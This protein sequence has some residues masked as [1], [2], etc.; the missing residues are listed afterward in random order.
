MKNFKNVSYIFSTISQ[1]SPSSVCNDFSFNTTLRGPI[2]FNDILESPESQKLIKHTQSVYYRG[3]LVYERQFLINRFFEQEHSLSSCQTRAQSHMSGPSLV[4]ISMV[5]KSTSNPIHLPVSKL[6]PIVNI[7]TV[8]TG[9]ARGKG[10]IT[11]KSRT[12]LYALDIAG[13]L[14]RLTVQKI[15]KK[16]YLSPTES[17]PR[18]P[19]LAHIDVGQHL[20]VGQH[21][22][23]ACTRN[24]AALVAHSRPLTF[25][26]QRAT[27]DRDPHFI[28][29]VAT[30]PP[31]FLACSGEVYTA[32][33][34]VLTLLPSL[35]GCKVLQIKGGADGAV[36]L[37]RDRVLTADSDLEF[38]CS[39]SK[40]TISAL[41]GCGP[42]WG[43]AIGKS[44]GISS[45]R[46]GVMDSPGALSE[47]PL[48]D[49]G[50]ASRGAASPA[51]V[52]VI[53]TDGS[54][55]VKR[56]G[57]GRW[58]TCKVEGFP[59]AVC[60]SNQFLFAT[61]IGM[62]A[63]PSAFVKSTASLSPAEDQSI[64]PVD[65]HGSSSFPLVSPG[66]KPLITINMHAR[67][68]PLHCLQGA[69]RVPV[70]IDA[71]PCLHAI[72]PILVLPSP[73]K[74]QFTTAI[75]QYM[76]QLDPAARHTATP[77][78][79]GL[80]AVSQW[81]GLHTLSSACLDRV[82]RSVHSLAQQLCPLAQVP[83][84]LMS[85]RQEAGAV[86]LC[87]I[88]QRLGLDSVAAQLSTILSIQLGVHAFSLLPLLGRDDA[89]LIRSICTKALGRLF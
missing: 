8:P 80:L 7:M 87:R 17:V 5:S 30:H 81:M 23:T 15:G 51:G 19:P 42:S 64:I 76:I 61:T 45:F 18:V 21:Y 66:D 2:T 37:T 69:A 29:S 46:F 24:G 71:L 85:I 86:Q 35:R 68:L 83:G 11:R 25:Y 13:H 31:M 73:T 74:H 41:T 22:V 1:L 60:A 88:L 77:G 14:H 38:T 62:P 43:S 75:D 50:R 63:H 44:G 40:P 48:P 20:V 32:K 6:A 58:R 54:L 36:A 79:L 47:A 67:N 59:T 72:I 34:G 57:E 53:A 89:A 9:P 39:H 55:L 78:I 65:I 26:R 12:V 84:C 27:T 3:I 33:D 28:A 49:G 4:M 56:R 10:K 82:L 70:P 16:Q 52:S